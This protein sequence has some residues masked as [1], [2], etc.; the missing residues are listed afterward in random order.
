MPDVSGPYCM[1][2]QFG[3]VGVVTLSSKPVSGCT[4]LWNIN[5]DEDSNLSQNFIQT[6]ACH[7]HFLVK[8]DNSVK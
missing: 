5:C 1:V 4:I 3:S 2:I 6:M 7:F 8:I